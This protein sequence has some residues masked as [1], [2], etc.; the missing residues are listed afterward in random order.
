MFP[1]IHRF[2]SHIIA[3]ILKPTRLC[4]SVLCLTR[5]AFSCELKLERPLEL[6]NDKI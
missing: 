5:N 1:Y 4:L 6:K 3:I 2:V